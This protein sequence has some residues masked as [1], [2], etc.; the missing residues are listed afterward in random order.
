MDN[1]GPTPPKSPPKHLLTTRALAEA[2]DSSSGADLTRSRG[3]GNGL[4]IHG[5]F[6]AVISIIAVVI[7]VVFFVAL[8]SGK[9]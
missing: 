9:M 1:H 3:Q 8:A 7:I 4:R 2:T 5:T 6:F